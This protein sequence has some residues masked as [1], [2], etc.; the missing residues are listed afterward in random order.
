MIVEGRWSVEPE[1]GTQKAPGP[2]GDPAPEGSA[3]VDI[4][5]ADDVVLA[6]VGADLNLDELQGDL[7]GVGEAVDAADREF[8]AAYFTYSQGGTEAARARAY[9]M[10]YSI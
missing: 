3:P 8:S 7:A 2:Q 1:L 5:D 6:R 4:L 9:M 10:S